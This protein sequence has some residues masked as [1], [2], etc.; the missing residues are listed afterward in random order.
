MKDTSPINVVLFAGGGG[1]DVGLEQAGFKVH[2][3]INHDPE[4]IAMHK[5][6][7][8]DCE[9]YT[10]DVFTVPPK[11]ACRGREVDTLWASPDCKHFSKA[12]AG[13]PKD[14]KIR[15]LAWV[16]E[17]WALQVSP[18]II[19]VE[20][21]EE[22]KTWGPL[23]T[24][25]NPIPEAAG[26][27]FKAWLN[28]LRRLGYAVEY[29]ELLA[30]DYG[31]ATIRKR[32]FII[33][34]RDG[35]PIVWPEQT[36]GPGRTEPHRSAA[37]CI[38]FDHGC[39]SIFERKKPLAENTLRRIAAGIRRYV[40]ESENP[41]IVTY[42][43]QKQEDFR[44][45]PLDEPLRTQTTENRHGLVA[46]FL[47][48]CQHSSAKNGT[49]DAASPLHTITAHPKGGGIALSA[50]TLLKHYGGVVG[51]P[52]EKPA[53]TITT[54]DHHSLTGAFITKMRNNNTATPADAPL[55]TISAGGQH[56][57]LSAVNVIQY[58]GCSVAHDLAAP[59][60]TV[61]QRERFG[62][63]ESKCVGGHA[64]EVKELLCRFRRKSSWGWQ[65][66]EFYE[67]VMDAFEGQLVLEDGV[68]V[69][70]DIGLR[71]LLP[72]ELFLCQGF[73]R[74]FIIAP[75]YKGKPL[76]KTA[77][78]KMCGNSVPPH[79]ARALAEANRV[80]PPVQTA[81]SLVV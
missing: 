47:Q 61:T 45:Q 66:D 25:G 53:G 40:Q 79:F 12:L 50:V 29:R 65:I 59:I 14:K 24:H 7:F 6:N 70:A 39:P 15:D 46:P 41:F 76:T 37:E 30:C 33:A 10:Q 26:Q 68:Y 9:H 20:N 8:P 21:V 71:M 81:Q 28:A 58:N 17:K 38:D 5:A 1:A 64:A 31:A 56:H 48:H 13:N 32:L 2:V 27:T 19:F 72:K 77:Q 18:R 4:A 67:L 51:Q 74:T 3:A 11:W 54:I 44:G 78:V 36:H 42:Y 55:R 49:M 57:A 16:V 34:R 69:I 62:L 63:V 23:D 35:L 52:I 43:G 60:N 22:F 80:L 75:T 73:P